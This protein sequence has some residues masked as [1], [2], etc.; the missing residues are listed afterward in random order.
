MPK[1]SPFCQFGRD[2]DAFWDPDIHPTAIRSS[3]FDSPGKPPED[4][5][6]IS[7]VPSADSLCNNADAAS[8]ATSTPSP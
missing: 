5:I 6:P 7:S 8:R 4:E 3:K 1:P 2:E